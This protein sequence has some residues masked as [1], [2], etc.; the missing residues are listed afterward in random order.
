MA[1]QA[2]AV[3]EAGSEHLRFLRRPG[4]LGTSAGDDRESELPGDDA[5]GRLWRGLLIGLV[6]SL[7]AFWGPLGLAVW[8]WF[9]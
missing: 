6:V 2:G 3:S 8:W 1:P 4:A 5:P 7:S 9:R